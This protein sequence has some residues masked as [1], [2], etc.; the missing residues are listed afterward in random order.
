M[1]EVTNVSKK[2]G[3]FS[4]ENISFQLPDG[5]IMGLI[6]ANGAGKTT[7]I[8]LLLGLFSPD[9][10]VIRI[11]GQEYAT[12]EHSIREQIG[13]VLQ[14]ELFDSTLT[15]WENVDYYGY[16]YEKYDKELCRKYMEEFELDGSRKY[17]VFSKGEKLNRLLTD[18]VSDGAHSVLISTHQTESLERVADYITFLQKGELLFSENIEALHSRYKMI[19]GESYKIKLVPKERIIYMEEGEYGAKALAKN[20]RIH[21]FD[22]ALVVEDATIE[23]MMYFMTK[24]GRIG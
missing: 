9:S 3:S 10:G 23:E 5:Y 22:P 19:Q 21:P 6:G 8:K 16:Y 1:L 13:Y 4:M 7:L 14:E 15:A 11:D 24:G 12:A 17:K 18:F 2:R 20:S